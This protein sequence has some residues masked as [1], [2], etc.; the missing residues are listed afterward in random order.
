MNNRL[1]RSTSDQ[2]LGGVAAGIARTLN[3]DPAIVR[4]G[5]VLGTLLTHGALLLVYLVLW[6][7]L[8]TP[9]S[10][11][12][13]PGDILRENVNEFAARVGV[14]PPA[15]PATGAPPPAAASAQATASATPATARSFDRN[16]VARLVFM[17][18]LGLLL[19]KFL[20]MGWF[21]AGHYHSGGAFFW[22]LLLI[23]GALWWSRRRSA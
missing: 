15:A 11:A 21:W 8:P 23:L 5:V 20:G 9:G 22:P 3:V 13:T 16:G 1:Y 12:T 17:A 10:T 19:L 6:A 7:I 18:I 14:N 2:V 4:V